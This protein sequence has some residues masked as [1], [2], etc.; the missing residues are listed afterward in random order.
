MQATATLRCSPSVRHTHAHNLSNTLTAG[1]LHIRL[2]ALKHHCW[3]NNPPLIPHM[4]SE[5]V[6]CHFHTM[7]RLTF[8]ML[9]HLKSLCREPY[10]LFTGEC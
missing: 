6:L 3:Y 2:M 10:G 1:D 8:F 7:L 4:L 5:N 9:S